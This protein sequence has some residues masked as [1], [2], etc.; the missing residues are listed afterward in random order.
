[1]SFSFKFHVIGCLFAIL[2]VLT[3]FH[4]S[5]THAVDV[6]RA[7]T[8]QLRQL[9]HQRLQEQTQI[10]LFRMLSEPTMKGDLVLE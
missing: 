6:K 4:L 8:Q 10:T 1:M 2:F 3:C 9:R 5:S 7:V